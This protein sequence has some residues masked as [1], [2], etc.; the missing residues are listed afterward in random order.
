MQRIGRGAL[1]GA[2]AVAAVAAAGALG[3]LAVAATMA[4]R[5]VRPDRD[6]QPLRVL[7]VDPD[8]AAVTLPITAESVLPGRYTLR[9]DGEAGL[10]RLGRI[11]GV[12]GDAV[13]REVLTVDRGRLRAGAPAALS[14]WWYAHPAELG[15][16]TESVV[17]ETPIGPAP[18]W[19][20]RHPRDR[21]RWVIHVHGRGAARGE[22]I[23][24]LAPAARAGYSSLAVSYRNDAGAP[25]G[26]NGR[27]A[28]GA[29]EWRDVEAAIELAVGHGAT[30]ICLFGWSMGGS[31]AVQTLRRSR[32]APLIRGLVLDSPALEW[33]GL[34][35][36]HAARAGVPG[37]LADVGLRLLAGGAVRSGS[38]GGVPLDDLDVLAWATELAVPVLLHSSTGDTFVPD[39]PAAALAALRPDLVTHRRMAIAEHV[40]LWN[41]DPSGW[42][43]ATE[44]WLRGLARRG[45]AGEAQR[46]AAGGE[47]RRAPSRA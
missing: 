7:G 4:R 37:P 43:D 8:A 24:G 47:P 46:A 32:Y 12:A 28:L 25:R 2:G 35:R 11:I 27:Y 39:G 29:E 41:L 31:I 19:L 44:G 5:A 21:G 36:E 22:T 30:D 1:V 23:R 17:V 34:L 40:R 6:E 26:E 13:T 38:A 18:A 42:E 14:G 16:K 33:R 3:G 15:L 9:F 20:V 10:A 45:R